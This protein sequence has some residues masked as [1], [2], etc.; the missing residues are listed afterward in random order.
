MHR[1]LGMIAESAIK[2]I[3]ACTCGNTP[4]LD[5]MKEQ[6][7]RL[8]VFATAKGVLNI[9]SKVS[10]EP[11]KA[12]T[13]AGIDI[14]TEVNALLVA[15]KMNKGAD[16]VGRA[17][18]AFMEEFKVEEE[19][20]EELAQDEAPAPHEQ[21]APT[22]DPHGRSTQ[23]FWKVALNVAYRKLGDV[24]EPIT[25]ACLPEVAVK[26]LSRDIE[27]AFESMLEKTRRSMQ[28]GLKKLSDS[29]L[30]M[31]DRVEKECESLASSSASRRL[32]NA[33]SRVQVFAT[34]KT[35]MN[36]GVHVEYEALK[37]LSLGGIDIHKEINQFIG[38]WKLN[39]APEQI[40]ENF[41]SF[42]EDF[43]QEEDEATAPAEEHEP[44]LS[45]VIREALEAADKY[46]QTK[47]LDST[48]FPESVRSDFEA[49]VNT[50]IEHMLK[51][52]KKTMQQGLRE[53]A[54]TA[55][56]LMRS[57]NEQN[58]Q[59]TS[60]P[61]AQSIWRSARKL[62]RLTRRTVVDYGTHI[63]YEAMKSLHVGGVA[64]HAELNAFIGAWSLGNQRESG[65]P[66]GLLMLKCSEIAGH[67]EM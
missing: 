21:V 58:K 53:L 13:V 24:S 17:L 61:G 55:D 47:D 1:G 35:L 2:L 34:A 25:E 27:D 38:A 52:R 7:T 3:E 63:K 23:K 32:R 57:A 41:A 12:L 16:E 19:T 43:S 44:L 22:D 66:F 40:G 20:K 6:A 28:A 51:K 60:N 48:C 54:D 9:G 37:T 65:K 45:L 18:K 5:K 42:F 64:I 49:G 10:Y 14:H 59:C 39:S 4:S 50:A 26:D 33:A 30:T 15:W 56:K 36:F 62:Q 8:K 11:M 31:L 46:T 29:T 67:D